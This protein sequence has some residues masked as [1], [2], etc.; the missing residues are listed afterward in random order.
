M[1]SEVRKIF[2]IVEP[3]SKHD[4]SFLES[5]TD[6]GIQVTVLKHTEL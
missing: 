4:P 2:E 1:S 5:A 6:M 3:L